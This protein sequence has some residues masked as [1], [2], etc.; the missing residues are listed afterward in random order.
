ML[1]KVLEECKD[2]AINAEF[3]KMIEL[4]RTPNL[5]ATADQSDVL[6][7]KLRKILDRMQ[8]SSGKGQKEE[9]DA[10]K[11]ALKKLEDAIAT[12]KTVR[13][14]TEGKKTDTPELKQNQQQATKKAD[15]VAKDVQK[16]LDK[17]NKTPN[18]GE[19]AQAK[20]ENKDAGK[21]SKG[22]KGEA[23]NDGKQSGES[24]KGSPK[25]GGQDPKAAKG[26]TKP[27]QDKGGAPK[28][29]DPKANAKAGEKGPDGM[30]D[31]PAGAKGDKGDQAKKGEQGQSKDKGG[32]K[33]AKNDPNKKEANAKDAGKTGDPMKDSPQGAAKSE[34]KAGGDP[35]SAQGKPDSKAKPG[36][37]PMGGGGGDQKPP[38]ASK[39][40]KGGDKGGEGKAGGDAKGG[41]GGKQ[42]EAKSGESKSGQGQAKEG[43]AAP[44][45]GNDS[46][47]GPQA[48]DKGDS[49]SPPPS[50]DPKKKD[51][52][53]DIAQTAKKLKEAGYDQKSAEKEIE[54]ERTEKAL[55]N[56]ADAIAKMEDAK[57][58]LEKL[59]RQMREN[60]IERVLAALQARCEKM[61]MLQ[62][63]VLAGTVDV[64]AAVNKNPDKKPIREN[65]VASQ[66]LADKEKEIVLEADKCIQILEGEGSAV[67]FPEVFQQL[68]EDMK[69]VQRRLDVTDVGGVTQNIEKDIINTLKQMIEALKEEQKNNNDDKDAKPGPPG[70][71]GP[72]ADPKLLKLIQELKMVRALQKQ[73]ND[74]TDMYGK[75]YPGEQAN[76]PQ[77]IRDLRVLAERQR[78][79]QD[80]V[81]RISK[82]DNQ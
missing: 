71:S 29:A 72:P 73:V 22:P 67:A 79:I 56:Q 11:A 66:A 27:G 52:N 74:R 25:D 30:K 28:D 54:K 33:N 60:E 49:K 55:K 26:E 43:G 1:A 40:S 46:P 5:R 2:L 59:L 75:A 80:I 38:V 44:M 45:G 9:I 20:G 8:D 47:K 63:Q 57:K 82:G 65:K 24:S 14:Q 10:I 6:T 19:A 48:S 50:S 39:E 36:G 62:T 18:G 12:Q 70:K 53:D 31:P 4:L 35:K 32:D 23:K 21:D 7:L 51:G 64:D 37:D 61:L 77:V 3:V 16:I 68:R 76:D 42:G 81:S 78:R 69:Q 15:D 13:E 34:P 58:K 41:E 17:D